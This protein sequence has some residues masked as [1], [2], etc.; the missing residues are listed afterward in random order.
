MFIRGNVEWSTVLIETLWNVKY[1]QEAVL[2][3]CRGY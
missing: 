3:G 1:G 2:G